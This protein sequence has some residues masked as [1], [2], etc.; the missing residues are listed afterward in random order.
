M[1][2]GLHLG[3]R[4]EHGDPLP[5]VGLSRIVVPGAV[6]GRAVQLLPG[7][8]LLGGFYILLLVGLCRH[9][10]EG[11]N[12]VGTTPQVS[13]VS[14]TVDAPVDSG[15]FRTVRL[16]RIPTPCATPLRSVSAKVVTLS[17]LVLP[18]LFSSEN[19]VDGS[20]N[21]DADVIKHRFEKIRRLDSC[22]NLLMF[23]RESDPE[24]TKGKRCDGDIVKDAASS[25]RDL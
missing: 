14:G 4:G 8:D 15:I 22:V 25:E 7:I 5:A 13:L 9:P 11:D 19:A 2:Q 6:F 3:H 10:E 21:I 12:R 20:T 24:D 17:T 23:I 18:V 16:M 1:G